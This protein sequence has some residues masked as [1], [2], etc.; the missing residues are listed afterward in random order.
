VDPQLGAGAAPGIGFA[1][2]SNI[3]K[4]VA[5][6]LIDTGTVTNSNRAYL[7]VQGGT[8]TGGGVLVSQLRPSGPAAQAGISTGDVITAVNGSATPDT[9]TL[10]DVLA[11]L[12]P[13]QAVSVSITRPDGTA[14]TSQVALGQSQG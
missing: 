13:G 10:A 5:T 14:Q 6:Q 7:G 1:I 9:T 12:K 4:N 11:G 8:T 3:V 2:P